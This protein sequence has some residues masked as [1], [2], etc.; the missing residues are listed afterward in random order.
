MILILMATYNGEKYIAA[1]IESLLKQSYQDF[2][3]Y[4]NDDCSTD[5][6]F[7]ILQE[8]QKRYPEKIFISENEQNSGNAK[9]NFI[10]MMIEKKADYVMLC[11]QDDVW[12][13]DKIAVTIKR[14]KSAEKVYGKDMPI[15]VHTDLKIV[16]CD[17]HEISDSFF[18]TMNVDYKKTLLRQQIVQ[19]TLTGCTAMY[20]LALAKLITVEPN[21]MVMH[22]WW[23]MLVA[24]AFGKIVTIN[25]ATILYRQHGNNAVGTRNMKSLKFMLGFFMTKKKYIKRALY[26]SC[27][28]AESFYC[29]YKK[30]LSKEQRRLVWRYAGIKD[31]NK[32]EK[33]TE[34]LKLGTFKNGWVRILSQ[35][36][37]V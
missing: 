19:N 25:K 36:L 9:H 13:P 15:L 34:I 29:I 16:N 33:V 12:L 24:A 37:C 20:N 30:K 5:R 8:Y 2:T 11:D 32:L 31:E 1:Q 26:D 22:D 18:W 17:L 3:I 10:K 14:M 27:M 23:L 7:A 28:Q 4:I 6:T 35:L 21:F